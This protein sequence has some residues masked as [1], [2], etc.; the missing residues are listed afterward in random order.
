M[1]QPGRPESP[2]TGATVGELRRLLAQFITYQ[3]GRRPRM[4]PYLANLT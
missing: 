2:P 1:D 4:L 3:M